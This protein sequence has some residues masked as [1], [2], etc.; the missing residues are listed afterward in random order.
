MLNS[1]RNHY[2]RVWHVLC[3]RH[4]HRTHYNT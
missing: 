3:C 4:S 1:W 2:K